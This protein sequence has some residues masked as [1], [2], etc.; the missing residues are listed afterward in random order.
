MKTSKFNIEDLMY[1]IFVYF[2]C[3]GGAKIIVKVTGFENNIVSG[4]SEEGSHWCN[5][6]DVEPTP[7]NE[8]TLEKIGFS[9]KP[10]GPPGIHAKCC[11]ELDSKENKCL[12]EIPDYG[13]YKRLLL[14]V[15]SEDAECFN[16]SC[17]YVHEL[18]LALK[19]C[20]IRM[21]FKL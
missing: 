17:N 11:Y 21:E 8:E 5:I 7:L 12:L 13:K 14:N 18:Q 9:K 16:I 10:Y 6:K 1:G 20:K 19:M 15:D 3:V 2:N 4:I